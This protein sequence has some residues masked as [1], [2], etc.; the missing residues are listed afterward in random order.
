MPIGSGVPSGHTMG[1]AIRDVPDTLLVLSMSLADTFTVPLNAIV[2]PS[3]F[4]CLIHWN[5][6]PHL[7]MS[8]LQ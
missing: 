5:C 3:L 1:C 8:S 2:A 7:T 6:D 4:S